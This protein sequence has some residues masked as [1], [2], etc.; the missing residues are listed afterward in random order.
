MIGGTIIIGFVL[1]CAYQLKWKSTWNCVRREERLSFPCGSP[2]AY[3]LYFV[4]TVC[5]GTVSLL[6]EFFYP[7]SQVTLSE[8][9][10]ENGFSVPDP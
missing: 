4:V 2:L 8:G 7:N 5:T 10:G 1:Q 9:K 6:T 3:G